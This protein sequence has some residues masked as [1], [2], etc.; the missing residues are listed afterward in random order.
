[1]DTSFCILSNIA[2]FAYAALTTNSVALF[3][4]ILAYKNKLTRNITYILL[5]LCVITG[6]YANNLGIIGILPIIA[7]TSYTLLMFITKNEQQM[8]Y[9]LASNLTLWMIHDFYVQAYPSA[10]TDFILSVWTVIQ[11][12]KNRS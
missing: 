4:N 5:I 7:S 2:L 9:A 1:M 12:T 6:L 8:R 11:I 3:R 10:I